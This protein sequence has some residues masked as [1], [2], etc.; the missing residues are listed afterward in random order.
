MIIFFLSKGEFIGI[1]FAHAHDRNIQ[2]IIQGL[3]VTYTGPLPLLPMLLLQI[4]TFN[5]Y[6]PIS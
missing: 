1:E 2:I 4:T 3:F 6:F 5:S